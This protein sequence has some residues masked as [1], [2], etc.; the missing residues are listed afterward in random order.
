MG[1]RTALSRR[2]LVAEHSLWTVGFRSGSESPPGSALRT[3]SR[4]IT[5]SELGTGQIVTGVERAA[6][7]RWYL[8]AESQDQRSARPSVACCQLAASACSALRATP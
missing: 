3:G 6:G 5:G 7:P 4:V 1:A 8:T 2:R